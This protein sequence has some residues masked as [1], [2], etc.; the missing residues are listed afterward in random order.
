MADKQILDRLNDL[1]FYHHVDEKKHSFITE[2]GIYTIYADPREDGSIEMFVYEKETDEGTTKIKSNRNKTK[3]P[4]GSFKM[5][6]S[7]KNDLKAKLVS[8][9]EEVIHRR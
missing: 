7:W 6:D 9:I 8:R 3:Y 5:Q 1:G 2:Y 4:I